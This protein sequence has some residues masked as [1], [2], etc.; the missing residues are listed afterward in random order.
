[1]E[2]A[3]GRSLD[4]DRFAVIAD[5]HGNRWALTAVLEDIARRGIREIVNAGDHLF[6]PL[7]PAGT[8]VIL[9]R[10][11]FP[12]VAGNQDRELIDGSFVETRLNAGHREWLASLPMRLE[13][14]DGILLFHGTPGHDDVYLLE[15]VLSDGAVSLATDDEISARLGEVPHKLLLCGHTHIPRTVESG[16]RMIVNPGSVGL[17]AY[18]DGLPVPHVMETGSP[19][20]R[21]A[22]VERSETGWRVEHVAIDYDVESAAQAAEHNGRPDWAFRLRTGR[23]IQP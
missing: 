3:A 21:Y 20:A 10:L 14:P 15:S 12:S 16:G 5:V 4:M 22:V 1:L 17:Q 13:L 11:D 18:A 8:A 2:L 6:G 19:Q 9:I 7:D 23:A